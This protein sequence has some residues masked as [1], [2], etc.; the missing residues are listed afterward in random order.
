VFVFSDGRRSKDFSCAGGF[1]QF[2]FVSELPDIDWVPGGGVGMMVDIA[3]PFGREREVFSLVQ[4]LSDMGWATANAR[5]SIQQ[6][7][8]NW[9]GV[10][11][12]GFV[13][14][15]PDFSNRYKEL[16]VVHHTEEFCY[17][18]VCD[19][20][21]YTL[22]GGVSASE[23]R[24]VW[25][26][27]LSFQLEGIP[28]DVAP[29]R[30][31]CDAV[32]VA[33]PVYF[34]PQ[35]DKSVQYGRIGSG[36]EPR[37][38]PVAYMVRIDEDEENPEL[39]EWVVGIVVKNP[40]RRGLKAKRSDR[41]DWMPEVLADSELLVCALGSLHPLAHAVGG[42]RLRH[43]ESAWTSDALVVRP[44]ADWDPA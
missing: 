36:D 6:A 4:K 17:F 18:D 35:D 28:L 25:P 33:E 7:T 40:G 41:P 42:Y 5:W 12:T 24:R 32:G 44:M 37:L 23:P 2:V 3:L 11:A 27:R 43:C 16:D 9:H 26:C 15:L 22:T 31:L 14:A 13:E 38:E 8:A 1:G 29:L 19:G 10:G 39:R 30:E 21:F 20:G 34:R